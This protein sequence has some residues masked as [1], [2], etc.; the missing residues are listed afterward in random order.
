M[1]GTGD[2]FPGKMC[3]ADRS[4]CIS[5][6]ILTV[7]ARYRSLPPFDGAGSSR[8]RDETGVLSTELKVLSPERRLVLSGLW[9]QHDSVLTTQY[10]LLVVCLK[11][12]SVPLP[13]PH[14]S[15]QPPPHP[16]TPAAP[17]LPP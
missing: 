9:V 12:F 4:S 10:S 5:A 16:E 3:G 6:S 8:R 17:L 2:S 13:T 14:Q 15:P 1:G 11:C 7:G